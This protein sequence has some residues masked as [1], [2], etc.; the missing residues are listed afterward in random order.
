MRIVIGSNECEGRYFDVRDPSGGAV[1]LQV[2]PRLSRTGRT[3][4]N[5]LLPGSNHMHTH[6]MGIENL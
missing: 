4:V 2:L 1:A 3:E 6:R 5:Y